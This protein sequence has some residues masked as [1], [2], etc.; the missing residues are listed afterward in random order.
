MPGGRTLTIVLIFAALLVGGAVVAHLSG[1]LNPVY[2]RI[3]WHGLM[4]SPSQESG[5]RA[6]PPEHGGN[7]G[8]SG[9]SMPGMEMP[10]TAEAKTGAEPSKLPGYSTVTITPE[11]QQL[12]GVRIGEVKRD[13][14]LMSI[15]AVGIIEPDQTRLARIQTRVSGWV[16]KLYVDFVGKH[17]EKGEPLLEIYSPELLASQEAYL[18]AL[19]G[20]QTGFA[21]P[22]RE[23]LV[24]FGVAPE[25]IAELERTGKARDT[26]LLRAPIEGTILARSVYEGSYVEPATELYKLADLSIVWVQAKIYEFELPHVEIGQPVEVTVQSEPNRPFPGKITFV[27]PVVQEATRTVRVRV[28]IENPQ[29]L[30]KPG[31]YADLQIEHDMGEGLLIPE[32]AVLRTGER[33][34]CFRSLPGGRFDPVEVKLGGRFGDRFEIVSGLS[35]GDKIVVSAGFLI[36]SESRLKATTSG[37]AGGHKHGG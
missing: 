16:T 37:A 33:A 23:R 12:I 27:E 20:P 29:E 14:L 3:G 2:H 24:L 5:E 30:L 13:K 17:V 10:E 15:R 1:V 26:L 22:S 28:E 4:Q 19:S 6:A 9:M 18:I 25:E 34:I 7:A 21:K 8:H 36:D 32:S 11:R 35:D 31:M